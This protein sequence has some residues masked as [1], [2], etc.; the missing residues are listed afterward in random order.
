VTNSPSKILQLPEAAGFFV[1]LV[2]VSSLFNK[3]LMIKKRKGS[4]ASIEH[5]ETN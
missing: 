3:I 5:L 4:L 1:P 2:M